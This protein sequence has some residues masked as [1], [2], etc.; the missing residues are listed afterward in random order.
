MLDTIGELSAAWGLADL[1]FVGGS[2]GSRGG[3]N[4]IE[5]AAFGAAVLFGP[6]TSNFRDVVAAFRHVNACVQLEAPEQLEIKLQQ[7]LSRPEVRTEL[8]RKARHVV[9]E[10]QGATAVTCQLLNQLIARGL[11]SASQRENDSH[12][13]AA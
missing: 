7:L 8:G 9:M 2:F 5:P 10:S 1:A 12:A 3:Q 6:N 13:A 11:Q 4:M